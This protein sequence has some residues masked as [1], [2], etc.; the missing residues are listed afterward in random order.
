MTDMKEIELEFRLH[1]QQVVT[2]SS[3]LNSWSLMFSSRLFLRAVGAV[4]KRSKSCVVKSQT[5]VDKNGV[6]DITA[7]VLVQ[8]SRHV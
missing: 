8:K 5:Y 3:R 2:S 7:D 1:N 4:E 6:V